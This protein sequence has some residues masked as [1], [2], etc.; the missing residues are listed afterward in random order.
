MSIFFT[1]APASHSRRLA[2]SVVAMITAVVVHRYFHVRLS[3]WQVSRQGEFHVF[4][5]QATGHPLALIIGFDGEYAACV[6]IH[7]GV[8]EVFGPEHHGQAIHVCHTG[9]VGK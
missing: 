9:G 6:F 2:A 7:L 8:I 4:D 1:T 3:Q 5:V